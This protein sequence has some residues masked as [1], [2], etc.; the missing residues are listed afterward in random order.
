MKNQNP[1][2]EWSQISGK[3]C[4]RF[5]FG[6]RLTVNEAEVAIEEWRKAFQSKID[7]AI[8][9]IWDCNKMRGYDSDARVKWTVA[10]K[11]MK[12]QIDSIW[13]ISDS[14]VIR[15]G[16]SVM[17]FFSNLDIKPISAES[18]IVI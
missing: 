8:I 2:I 3:E 4:L 15:I 17:G 7:K 6:E 16:A 11:E 12:S 10:L 18:E 13:L 14:Q 5:I 1:R 9:L